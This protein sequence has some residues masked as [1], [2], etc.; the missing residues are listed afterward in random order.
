ME[1]YICKVQNLL[2]I[3]VSKGLFY[4]YDATEDLSDG[5]KSQGRDNK[6]TP[7]DNEL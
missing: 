6:R 2:F 1:D 7:Y 4:L 3:H 5:S